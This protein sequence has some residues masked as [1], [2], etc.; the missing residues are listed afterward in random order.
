VIA[1]FAIVYV[2]WGSTY[3]AIRFAVETLPP[4]LMG[5]ARFL[6]AGVALFLWASLRGA[7]SEPGQ[8][9]VA[10]IAGVL[11]L[12]GGNGALVWSEQRVASGIAALL[13]ATLPVW[14]VLLD[15]LRPGGIRP[16]AGVF[17]GLALGLVGLALLVGPAAIPSSGRSEVDLA[18]AGVLMLGSI[19]WAAGSIFLRGAPHATSAT[20]SNAMQMLVGGATLAIAGVGAGEL[21]QLDPET[22]SA[23]SVISLAYLAVFGSLIGFSAYTYILRVSTPARVATYAYVNPVVA[24][25]LGWAFASEPITLRTLAA[26]AIILA[27]VA[28][29]GVAGG[30]NAG[31]DRA[32]SGGVTDSETVLRSRE[33]R[34]RLARR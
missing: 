24:M 33:R 19:S 7:R 31:A 2:V 10:G 1:A 8:W 9:R 23:R 11:L 12:F 29:I 30:T 6:V 22:A 15:W 13:V 27:G 17:A 4:F 25:L 5:G 14:M 28:I 16:R 26:A 34:A 21:G 20:L 32:T 3:L 18:A